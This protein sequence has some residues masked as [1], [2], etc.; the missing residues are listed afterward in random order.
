MI[1]PSLKLEMLSETECVQS[2]TQFRTRQSLLVPVPFE[3]MAAE[4]LY[5]FAKKKVSGKQKLGVMAFADALLVIPRT[6]AQNSGFD[7][8]EI[9]LKV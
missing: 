6:L 5:E 2:P 1:T 7:A 3:V 4:H 8:Q 9:L